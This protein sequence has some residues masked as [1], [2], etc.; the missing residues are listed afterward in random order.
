MQYRSLGRSGLKVS[1]LCLGT[2]MFGDQ[3]NAGDAAG[4]V[5]SARDAGVNFI[6]TADVYAKGESERITGQLVAK[7]R[8]YWVVATKVANPMVEGDPNKRGTGRKWVL[9]AVEDS[10]K[11]LGTDYLDIYYIH[12]DTGSVPMEETVAVMGD[13]IR[14]GKI[15]YWG[16]SNLRG[17]RIAEAVRVCGDLGVPRPVVCQPYYN[18]MNRQ[19]ENDILPACHHYGIGVVPYSPLARG[20]LIGKYKAGEKPP[21][22]SR[23]GRND[24]RMMQTEFREESLVIAQTLKD[25]AQKKGL[26]ASDFAVGWVLRNPII[27]SVI[28][29]PR[30]LEQWNGYLAALGKTL[31]DEDEALVD[32]LVQAGHPSTPG[33]NDPAYPLV[34]RPVT[35]G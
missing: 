21:E 10:L 2:M 26:S 3:T 9:R 31:D 1:R 30:T 19:P 32:S 11:R 34:G 4:I 33:Y 28:G 24:K 6:D 5:A 12:R 27:D 25:H 17:W 18:A 22:G 8:D 35:R 13:L 23:A 14:A 7:E 16:V 15:R 29:G 20:V